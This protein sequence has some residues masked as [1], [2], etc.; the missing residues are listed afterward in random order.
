MDARIN[1][2][3]DSALAIDMSLMRQN[4]DNACRMM[5]T[6]ANRDR[7]MLLCQLSQGEKCVSELEQATHIQQP[8]LS[9]QL[10]ILRKEEVV[11]TRR[12]GKQIYYKL[13]SPIAI[14]V[15]ELLYAT[16]CGK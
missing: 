5:K 8:T 4:A 6:L 12:D 9:Q 2:A 1:Q 7:L 14:A 11:S 13:S 3:P 10:A 15:M 16:Y